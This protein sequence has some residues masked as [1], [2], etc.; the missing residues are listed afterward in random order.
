MICTPGRGAD[1]KSLGIRKEDRMA[2]TTRKMTENP[3]IRRIV[4]LIREIGKREKDHTDYL[5]LSP[6]A[7]SRWK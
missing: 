6:G 4:G 2:T 5:G 1:G 3:V 7:M